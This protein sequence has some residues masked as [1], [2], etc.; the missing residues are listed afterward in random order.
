MV[1][2]QNGNIQMG[3][4]PH[5]L[6]NFSDPPKNQNPPGEIQRHQK[7]NNNFNIFHG[8]GLFFKKRCLTLLFFVV[9]SQAELTDLGLF[10]L[11]RYL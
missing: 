4:P 3:V 2:A 1:L 6:G 9:I 11:T 7:Q 8:F 10:L 5:C